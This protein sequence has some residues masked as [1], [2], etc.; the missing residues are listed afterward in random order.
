MP[1]LNSFSVTPTSYINSAVTTYSFSGVISKTILID[2]DTVTITPQNTVT[3]PLGSITCA[4]TSSNLDS[5]S[6]ALSGGGVKV[7]L[8]FKASSG[9]K[10]SS[11]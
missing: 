4:A 5:V 11:G 2:N 7:T 3:N 8:N 10:L 1:S 9:N 6:C